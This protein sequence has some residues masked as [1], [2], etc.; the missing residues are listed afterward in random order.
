MLYAAARAQHVDE[1]LRPALEKGTVI[2]C[3]RFLD[4]SIVYQGVVRR[5]GDVQVEQLNLWGTGGL[6]PDLVVVLDV[7]AAEGLRRAA[8]SPEA[9]GS[10]D[11]LELEGIDFHR[12][13]NEA[14][15]R[16]ADLDPGRYLVIDA[17]LPA[18]EIHA[19]VR[20][21]VLSRLRANGNHP[22]EVS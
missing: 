10:V 7:D 12:K 8:R 21:A 13:V 14:F 20:D 6:V 15:R 3:D 5:M 9:A 11:R 17:S 2:L 22:V 4:S 1:I 18:E 19:R 16:R